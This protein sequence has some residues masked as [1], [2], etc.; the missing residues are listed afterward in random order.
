MSML[1]DTEANK[2]GMAHIYIIQFSYF[3]NRVVVSKPPPENGFWSP[4]TSELCPST[5]EWY[6]P[7]AK[8]IP[9]VS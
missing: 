8:S 4:H 1:S 9:G 2:H 3:L 6:L 7:C 5:G